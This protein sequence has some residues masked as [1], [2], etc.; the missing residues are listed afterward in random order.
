MLRWIRLRRGCSR[1]RPRPGGGS[2]VRCPR[3]FA[4]R[5]QSVT[6]ERHSAK[7]PPEE[8]H[9]GQFIQLA[10]LCYLNK[11]YRRVGLNANYNSS[12]VNCNS[13]GL[14]DVVP[15]DSAY[16]FGKSRKLRTVLSEH[17]TSCG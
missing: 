9:Q 8:C 1:R 10:P 2:C 13:D 16:N 14:T 3:G 4:C 7:T 15:N 6:P 12:L 17:P 11:C 5:T